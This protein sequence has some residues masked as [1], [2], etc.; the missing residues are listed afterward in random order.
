M[1]YEFD[2]IIKNGLVV[3][4]NTDLNDIKDIGIKDGKIAKIDDNI[5]AT[6]AE[7]SFDVNGML[8]VPGLVDLHMHASTWLGGKYGHKMLAQ[9]GVTSALDMS[10]PIEGVMEIAKDHGVG[11][12]IACIEYVRP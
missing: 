10:G 2:V 9:A 7:E 12:N 1:A 3:D 4:P 11:L 5:S 6:T 8:V